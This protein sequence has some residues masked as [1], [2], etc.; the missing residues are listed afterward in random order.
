MAKATEKVAAAPLVDG[1][2]TD[3]HTH[4]GFVLADGLTTITV[5]ST[6]PPNPAVGDLW[7]DTS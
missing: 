1:E 4:A 6:A 2:E 3:L 5:S 7:V